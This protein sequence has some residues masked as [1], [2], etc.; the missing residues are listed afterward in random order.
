MAQVVEGVVRG[1]GHLS[2]PDRADEVGRLLPGPLVMALWFALTAGL[3]EG[4]W[5]VFQRLGLHQFLVLP[6]DIVWMAPIVDFL[7]LLLPTLLLILARRL[8]PGKL[9]FAGL[10]GILGGLPTWPDTPIGRA[11]TRRA[12]CDRA[13]TKPAPACSQAAIGPSPQWSHPRCSMAATSGQTAS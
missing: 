8:A 6:F 4:A 1:T 9:S 2:R 12:A 3:V 7:W 11:L 5:R 13:F 10:V